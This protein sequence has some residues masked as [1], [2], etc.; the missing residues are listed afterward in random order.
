MNW[1]PAAYDRL[2]R[3][4]ADRSR[5]QLIRRGTEYVLVPE[6]LRSDYGGEYLT[7][8]HNVTGRVMEFPL[9]EVESFV[10]LD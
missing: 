9:G 4:I 1:T 6:R 7:A 3:A 10:V 5:I 2:E 8:R